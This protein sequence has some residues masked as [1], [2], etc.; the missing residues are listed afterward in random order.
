MPSRHGNAVRLHGSDDQYE[1]ISDDASWLLIRRTGGT[2]TR[3]V[4]VR[5][6][7]AMVV[8]IMAWELTCGGDEN[9][10]LD[11]LAALPDHATGSPIRVGDWV[12]YDSPAAGSGSG[13]VL[14]FTT[15]DGLIRAHLSG[16]AAPVSLR[17]VH[18]AALPH[19]E[20]ATDNEVGSASIH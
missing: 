4:H 15:T 3:W 5:D 6:L 12:S 17:E 20:L 16:I 19:Q 18:A 1:V 8:P 9:R 7:A 13:R 11:E 10:Y 14:G 2:H